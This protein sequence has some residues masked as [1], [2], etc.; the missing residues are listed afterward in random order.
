MLLR[1]IQDFLYGPRRATL[2]LLLIAGGFVLLLASANLANLQ[3]SRAAKRTREIAIRRALGA[4]VSQTLK[5]LV[6][7]T[8]LLATAGALAGI[9]LAFAIVR[10][11]WW[12]QPSIVVD[13]PRIGV[14]LR[15]A[16]FAVALSL[17]ASLLACVAPAHESARVDPSRALSARSSSG[18]TRWL[19]WSRP[20]LIVGE[21]AL[22]LW[23]VMMAILLL[24]SYDNVSTVDPGFDAAEV[25][26]IELP[27]TRKE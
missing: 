4:S 2:T 27:L 20:S 19:R 21:V 5:P 1:P 16:G 11:L 17:G 6:V 7:E 23:A 3:L 18:A 12:S 9:A 24:E 14:D 26:T 25:L 22:T 15:V 13:A 10:W 8:L